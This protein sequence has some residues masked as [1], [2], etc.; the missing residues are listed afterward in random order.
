MEDLNRPTVC[1]STRGGVVTTIL[2]AIKDDVNHWPAKLAPHLRNGL[3]D[4]IETVPGDNMTMKS[5]KR[6]FKI[7]VDKE[8]KVS[9]NQERI[10]RTEIHRTG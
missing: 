4:H 10:R 9:A 7:K 3:A 5:G 6:F 1:E 8:G 2:V